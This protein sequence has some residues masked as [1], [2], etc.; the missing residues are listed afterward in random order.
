M[1]TRCLSGSINMRAPLW[2]WLPLPLA[3]HAMTLPHY[4]LD[5]LVYMSTDIVTARVSVRAERKFTATVTGAV[6]GS[7]AAGDKLETLSDF[8]G[9]FQPMED[10]Q[11]VILFLDRRPRQ[12]HFLYPQGRDISLRG[13]PFRSLSHRQRATRA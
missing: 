9:F 11:T 12:A 4:D 6:S 13:R 3:V 5:S 2:I 1:R 10:S 8:L 7:L